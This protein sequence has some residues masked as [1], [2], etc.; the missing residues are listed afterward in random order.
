MGQL[1]AH[2]AAIRDNA[3]QLTELSARMTDGERE[4][5]RHAL[6]KIAENIKAKADAI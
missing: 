4:I 3:R 6:G 1:K 2:I 5:T